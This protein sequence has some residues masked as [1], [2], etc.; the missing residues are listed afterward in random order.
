MSWSVTYTTWQVSTL[1]VQWS[2]RTVENRQLASIVQ[3]LTRNILLRHFHSRVTR[4]LTSDQS[5]FQSSRLKWWLVILCKIHCRCVLVVSRLESSF[6][7]SAAWPFFRVLQSAC[8]NDHTTWHMPHS[9]VAQSL[10]M[11][12]T[13]YPGNC[14]KRSCKIHSTIDRVGLQFNFLIMNISSCGMDFLLSLELNWTFDDSLIIDP[15]AMVNCITFY[16]SST[17]P[18]FHSGCRCLE[19]GN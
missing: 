17:S 12:T 19:G 8:R 4:R 1:L 11:F 5:L 3:L 16:Y 6:F 13:K 14:V 10:W 2:K 15:Q 9:T 7:P 18:Q